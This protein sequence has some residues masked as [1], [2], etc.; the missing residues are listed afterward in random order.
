MGLGIELDRDAEMALYQQISEAV[1][2]RID[3]G[4]LPRGSR[5][6]TIR[7][8]ADRLGVTRVTVHNAYTELQK[9]GWI[10]ATVGRGTFVT[11]PTVDDPL[12]LV[13]AEIS[14]ASVM[15]DATRLSRVDGMCMMA[16]ADPADELLPVREFLQELQA[17]SRRGTGLFDYACSLGSATLRHQVAAMLDH[18]GVDSTPELIQ[19]T[20]GATAGLA[21]VVDVLAGEGDAVLVE[22]PTYLGMLA[23]LQARGIRIVGVPVDE[24]GP[25]L[26]ALEALAVRER[27]RLFYTVPDFHNPTGISMSPVRRQRVLEIARRHRLRVV[28]DGV[29]REL[30]YDASP[31]APL[32]SV[33]E[34]SSVVYVDGFSKTLLPGL[35]IGFVLSPP[36]LHEKIRDRHRTDQLSGQPLLHKA[37]AEFLAK[38]RYREHLRR[39][40]PTYRARRDALLDTLEE[41]MPAEV[42]WTRPSGG[43]C[44]W[45]TLPEGVS[46]D[47]L[48]AE[49]LSR[50]IA[51]TPGEV[52]RVEPAA[53]TS[54]R[55]CFGDLSEQQI[56]SGIA[57]L[58]ELIGER[59][60]RPPD[61]RPEV[62][63]VVPFT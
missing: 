36:D 6:P 53:R 23:I 42:Q 40:M 25:D 63:E 60:G 13:S 50:G 12:K 62:E 47:G 17:V 43:F 1:V 19:I 61:G 7:D 27:P 52:F 20:A 4:Q 58:A 28:E 30:S 37:L 48:Y 56:R 11:G 18:L 38:G 14:P 9:G 54:L 31:S 5:L 49:A 32:K 33:D 15:R 44:C 21:L 35:R 29:Y 26:D 16:R 51:Y 24:E 55:L 41:Q 45:L 57:T 39:V 34:G 59:M 22:Q 8:L 2:R 3:S 10:E 46:F